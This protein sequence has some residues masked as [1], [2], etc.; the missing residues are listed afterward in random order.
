MYKI[1]AEDLAFHELGKIGYKISLSPEIYYNEVNEWFDN[2]EVGEKPI[3][4]IQYWNDKV[5]GTNI[6]EKVN[7]L[8]AGVDR[9]TFEYIKA[10]FKVLGIDI[11]Q[12]DFI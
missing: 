12:E 9:K 1:D 11:Y 4:N 7:S 2:G 10:T 5:F 3:N 8:Y 6:N